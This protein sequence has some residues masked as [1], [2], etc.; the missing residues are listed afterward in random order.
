[1]ESADHPL[2]EARLEAICQKGCRTV[3]LDI[4]RIEQGEDLPET[5]GLTAEERRVLLAE[6]KQIMAVY[7][8]SCPLS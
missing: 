2:V 7:G 6:L 1:M 3:Q 4:A 8:D 5:R